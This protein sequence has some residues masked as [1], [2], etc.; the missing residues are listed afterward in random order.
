MFSICNLVFFYIYLFRQF[1]MK[2]KFGIMLKL[3]SGSVIN[4]NLHFEKFKVSNAEMDDE[5]L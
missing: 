3:I 5:N 2:M 4:S 1:E